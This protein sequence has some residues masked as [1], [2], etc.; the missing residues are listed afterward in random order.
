[1][2]ALA[3]AW[4][5]LA[6][7]EQLVLAVLAVVV[8]AAAGYGSVA[9]RHLAW[10][11]QGLFFGFTGERIAAVAAGLPWWQVVAAP[12]VGGLLIGWFCHR[13]F[14]D[15]LPQAVAEVI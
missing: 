12:A 11:I 1:M 5:R 10:Q 14:R 13:V 9:F 8:G 6:Q 15:R 3:R 7:N 2:A 4:H